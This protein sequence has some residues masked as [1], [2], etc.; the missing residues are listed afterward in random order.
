M[1]RLQE[2]SKGLSTAKRFSTELAGELRGLALVT[3]L[4]LTVVAFE[5]LRP[6][7]IQWIFD[8]A[9]DPRAQTVRDPAFY[10]WTGAGA[11]LVFTAGRALTE[12]VGTLR[13][14]AI[15]HTFTR[16]L[17]LRIFAHLSELSPRFH[18]R[19]KSGDLLM[20]L[21]GDVPM[22][23][24]MVV[25]SSVAL[26]TRVVQVVGTIAVM[27]LVDIQ[28]T[29]ILLGLVPLALLV[30][31]IL[32]VRLTIAVRKQRRKEGELADFLHEAIAGN[33][34]VQ[35][36]GGTSHTVRRFARN[37]RRSARAGLKTARV[38]ARMSA[39]VEG[40]VAVALA[41]TLAAGGMRVVDGVLTPG[42]LLVFLSYVRGLMKPVRS[43][44]KQMAKIARGT[45]CGE[46]ILEVLDEAPEVCSADGLQPAPERPRSL[47]FDHVHFAYE[48]EQPVL[49]DVNVEFERGAV[50]ALLGK[51]GVGKSTL[52]SLAVRL[53][54]PDAGRVLLDGRDLRELDLDSLRARFG[55]SMQNVVLF[56]ET[57]REN[58][59]LAR[60]HASDDDL[61]AA[62]V[63]AGADEF[64]FDLPD[65]LD[66]ILGAGGV[67]LSG[68][69]ARRVSLARTLLRDAPILIVDEP[70]GGLDRRAAERVMDALQSR[71]AEQLV[72]VITHETRRL[73]LF[74]RIAFLP[75]RGGVRSGLHAELLQS[76]DAYA[77]LCGKPLAVGG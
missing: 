14:T 75:A 23:R 31:R 5:L 17:R 60:P 13:I 48:P 55:L 16:N 61:A 40:F 72:I 27:M 34:L 33:T 49:T 20:R 51:N 22:V 28:L 45:A 29:A 21:M 50:T 1:K 47:V 15:G 2:L 59:L 10:I 41:T 54:D 19:H 63:D 57:L 74:D 43:A 18:A 65:G 38:A 62:L 76:C 11:A 58:L 67:G 7:P 37:N 30:V 39:S 44:S 73:E 56:G 25:D 68:G 26:G 69:Q 9:L 70:F 36:L 64:V 12:Y 52:T 53:L 42:E 66:T 77:A 24:T 35:S 32:S 71:A 46:R 6:W 4:A 3:T 8:N